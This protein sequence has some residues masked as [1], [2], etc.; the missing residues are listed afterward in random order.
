MSILSRGNIP[1]GKCKAIGCRW[2]AEGKLIMCLDHW[3]K[4]PSHLQKAII[5][6][7]NIYRRYK[8]GLRT[9]TQAELFTNDEFLQAAA[10]A[11]EH[12][13]RLEGQSLENQF[14]E[15]LLAR[16]RLREA[17]QSTEEEASEA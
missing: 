11:V 5:D 9:P 10:D 13:A 4:L 2:A 14:R 15:A 16:Q 8:V 3:R 7:C 6:S 12:M 1:T 17:D